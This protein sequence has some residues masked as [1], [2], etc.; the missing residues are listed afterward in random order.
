MRGLCVQVA[1]VVNGVL[2]RQR[3][4]AALL[5]E[6]GVDRATHLRGTL[7]QVVPQLGNFRMD[8]GLVE[9]WRRDRA[10]G[11]LRAHSA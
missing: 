6:G 8:G 11:S 2:E 5:A 9:V 3:L 4:Q 10:D 7:G 1:E